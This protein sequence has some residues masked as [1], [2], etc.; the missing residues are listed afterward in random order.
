MIQGA[1]DPRLTY[2][3][4]SRAIKDKRGRCI[5]PTRLKARLELL[6]KQ[7]GEHAADTAA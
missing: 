2:E 5:T 3:A 1:A 7:E 6:K 4:L